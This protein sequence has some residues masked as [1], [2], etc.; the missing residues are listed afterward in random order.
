MA[1]SWVGSRVLAPGSKQRRRNQWRGKGDGWEEGW[2]TEHWEGIGSRHMSKISP[3]SGEKQPVSPMELRKEVRMA[4][5][6]WVWRVA[7]AGIIGGSQ[8]SEVG[9]HVW[10]LI[11]CGTGVASAWNQ[12]SKGSERPTKGD[13]D[14]SHCI[15]PGNLVR[16][17]RAWGLHIWKRFA[18]PMTLDSKMFFTVLFLKLFL[19]LLLTQ[20]ILQTHSMYTLFPSNSIPF[21]ISEWLLWSPPEKGNVSL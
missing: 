17:E 10:D 3:G 15:I 6:W 12:E 11:L 9:L 8:E 2:W 20:G 5:I 16:E 19:I 21:I 13:N 18:A 4:G 14:Y 7:G 1:L